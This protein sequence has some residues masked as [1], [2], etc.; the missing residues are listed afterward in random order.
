MQYWS[1]FVWF[2]SELWLQTELPGA[3]HTAEEEEPEPEP[4]KAALI[5]IWM[6]FDSSPV[7]DSKKIG[8][9]PALSATYSQITD[10]VY[11]L[12]TGLVV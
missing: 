6:L 12:N 11:R 7:R 8:M 5:W 1:N 2:P 4:H 3:K 10:R 9:D